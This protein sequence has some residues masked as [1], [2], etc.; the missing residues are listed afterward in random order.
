MAAETIERP[1]LDQLLDG[2]LADHLRVDALAE[3]EQI[4]ERPAF[5]AGPHDL[6]RAAAAKP[7]DRR[8][9]EDDLAVC[10]REIGLAAVDVRRQHLDAEVAGRRRCARP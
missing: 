8:Q 1:R 9:A 5:R 7:L 4:L 6:F 3:I 10:D 2:G